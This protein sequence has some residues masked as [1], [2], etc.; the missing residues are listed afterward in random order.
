MFG[1]IYSTENNSR[2]FKALIAAK[3]NNLEVKVSPVQ[4]GVTNKTDSYLAKFPMGK[5]PAF[6]GAD[7][8]HVVIS[9]SKLV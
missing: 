3:Y 9:D 8:F 2:T 7:G 4:M 1:T 6:E 5:V